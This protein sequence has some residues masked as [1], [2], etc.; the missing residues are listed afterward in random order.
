MA[1]DCKA[2]YSMGMIMRTVFWLVFM[3]LVGAG[4][5][6]CPPEAR[7]VRCSNGGECKAHDPKYE[8]CLAGRCVECVARGSCGTNRFCKD[9][10]CVVEKSE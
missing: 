2:A 5:A 7:N 10:V 9:G 6:G 1:L 8:Y 3:A 4:S